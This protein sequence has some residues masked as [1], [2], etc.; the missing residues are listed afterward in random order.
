MTTTDNP[1]RDKWVRIATHL[2]DELRVRGADVGDCIFNH[3]SLCDCDVVDCI[4]EFDEAWLEWSDGH[5]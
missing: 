1:E 2:Y 5:D 4:T 3:K